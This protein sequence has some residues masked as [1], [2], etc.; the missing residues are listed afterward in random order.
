M[1]ARILEKS[2]EHKWDEFIKTHPL[3]TIHQTP[4]WGHFRGK[5]WIIVLENDDKQP[6]A[7]RRALRAKASITRAEASNLIVGGSMIIHQ[8]LSKGYCWLY[9]AR[10]PLIQNDQMEALLGTLKSLAK[11][12]NAVFFRIDPPITESPKFKGFKSTHS[13]FQP[14]D[15][16]IIDLAKSEEEILK[17]M[18]QKG[19]YN[20]RLAEKKGVRIEESGD[21][22]AFYNLLEQ[23]TARDSFHGHDK[24]FYQRML[25]KLPKNAILYMAIYESKAIA[26]IIVT[27]F[28]DTAI[29]YFGASGNEYRNTMA[30]YLLQWHAMK[31]AKKKNLKYYDLLG[32]APENA[33]DHP[34]AGV[35]NFKKKFGGKHITYAPPQ[36]YSFKPFI[37]LLYQL[38][39]KMKRW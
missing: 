31:E 37:H 12:E 25:D 32:I 1:K 35:T 36:E 33:K 18:K 9:S 13:G 28:K 34:W 19:R 14:E 3:A 17:Q 15:T 6:I 27:H 5:Y 38:Y 16:L 7:E 30:P 20:I 29:Y 21:I 26:G 8:E 39:R 24:H 2:E 23:T 11:K 10:G 4:A 22:N